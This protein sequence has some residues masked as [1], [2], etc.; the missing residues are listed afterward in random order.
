MLGIRYRQAKDQNHFCQFVDYRVSANSFEQQRV[1]G[2]ARSCFFT[3][4]KIL[5]V[6]A[7]NGEVC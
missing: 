3:G 6:D 7:R 1:S 5:F 2:G 4:F